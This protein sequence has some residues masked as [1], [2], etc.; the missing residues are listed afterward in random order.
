MEVKYEIAKSRSKHKKGELN[1]VNIA[2][3]PAGSVKWDEVPE[4][5]SIVKGVV[6]KVLAPKR[7]SDFRRNRMM[8]S[9]SSG[10][11]GKFTI[12]SQEMKR[13]AAIKTKK[14]IKKGQ[15]Q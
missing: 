5:T 6:T 2:K 3:L 9:D 15:K 8:I 10:S 14:N 12:L 13:K 4:E 11:Y 7:N 1:A